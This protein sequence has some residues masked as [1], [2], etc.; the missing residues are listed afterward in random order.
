MTLADL[1]ILEASQSCFQSNP[2]FL[3]SFPDLMKL[4]EK[5]AAADGVRQYLATRIQ[6][7]I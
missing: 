1:A 3:S 7:G 4:R 5:V 2:R 6:R